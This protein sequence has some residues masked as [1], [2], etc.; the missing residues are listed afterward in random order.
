ME[1]T[2]KKFLIFL[3]YFLHFFHLIFQFLYI[4]LFVYKL[5]LVLFIFLC[6]CSRLCFLLTPPSHPSRF[7]SSVMTRT[8]VHLGPTFQSVLG[9]L[10][11]RQ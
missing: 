10:F 1:V 7:S 3:L 4:L 11:E 8:T 5:P 2:W 9:V 6:S